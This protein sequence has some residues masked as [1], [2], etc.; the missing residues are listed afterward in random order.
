MILAIKRAWGL[1]VDALTAP[2]KLVAAPVAKRPAQ[3]AAKAA[4]AGHFAKSVGMTKGATAKPAAA[5]KKVRLMEKRSA[6]R[7]R[8][9]K[10]ETA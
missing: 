6:A 9:F 7:T 4:S 2:Y 8:S 3:S 5:P 1:P 10:T